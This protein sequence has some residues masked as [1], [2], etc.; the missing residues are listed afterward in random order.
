MVNFSSDCNT[1]ELHFLF[2]GDNAL[3]IQAI[4]PVRTLQ[5]MSKIID[6]LENSPLMKFF[7]IS[8]KITFEMLVLSLQAYFLLFV[9]SLS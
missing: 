1:A 3:F 7:P 5:K 4:S 2:C 8:L 6:K 9:W